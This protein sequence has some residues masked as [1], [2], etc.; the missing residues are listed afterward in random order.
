MAPK[1]DLSKKDNF[2]KKKSRTSITI[3][4]KK[5]ILRRY[6]RGESTAAIRNALN[7]SETMLHTIRKDRENITA[8]FKAGAVSASTRALSG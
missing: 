6:N 3:E 1:C 8:A 2:G 7:L 4:Q 5:D